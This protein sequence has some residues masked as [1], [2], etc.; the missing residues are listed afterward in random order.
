ML[1][2]CKIILC[3]LTMTHGANVPLSIHVWTLVE[4][5]VRLLLVGYGFLMLVKELPLTRLSPAF[6]TNLDRSSPIP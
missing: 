3:A 4:S 5:Y 1:C 6:D 2:R